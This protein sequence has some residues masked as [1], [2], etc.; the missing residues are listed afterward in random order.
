MT[1][2]AGFIVSVAHVS[3]TFFRHFF[4]FLA[5]IPPQIYKINTFYVCQFLE[6]VTNI[7]CFAG[8]RAFST[9]TTLIGLPVFQCVVLCIHSYVQYV[10][11]SDKTKTSMLVVTVICGVSVAILSLCLLCSYV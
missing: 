1:V 2:C 3:L 5:Q 4:A 11:L 9:E 7:L 8:F 6:V 10:L